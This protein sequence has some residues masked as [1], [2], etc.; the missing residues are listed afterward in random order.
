MFQCK[1]GVY[2]SLTQ[3]QS[4]RGYT[5]ARD[6]PATFH[7]T[8]WPLQLA[9]SH[10]RT[11][12]QLSNVF[13]GWYSLCRAWIPI[14]T[15][16]PPLPLWWLCGE[17]KKAIEIKCNNDSVRSTSL[18]LKGIHM[19]DVDKKIKDTLQGNPYVK[20]INSLCA[21]LVYHLCRIITIFPIYHLSCIQ[22][23]ED[24]ATLYYTSL[25]SESI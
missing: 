12:E 11:T 15:H 18:T 23:N 17:R 4:A 1:H 14:H 13:Q 16:P 2:I 6:K 8:G 21:H 7:L 3:R 9:S 25:T 10:S 5:G 19:L 22:T 24:K 20:D